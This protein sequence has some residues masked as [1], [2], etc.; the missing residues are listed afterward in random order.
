MTVKF[1]LE[2]VFSS[3]FQKRTCAYMRQL[4]ISILHLNSVKTCFFFFP[5]KWPVNK[6][7]TSNVISGVGIQKFQI[8]TKLGP[9]L[10]PFSRYF[11]PLRGQSRQSLAATDWLKF[12]LV[13]ESFWQASLVA[14][15]VPSSITSLAQHSGCH[16]LME[17]ACALPS[18]NQ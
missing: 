6:D 18:L 2:L 17:H 8:C 13:W 4:E 1:I 9:M 5:N 11:V 10:S 3:V 14:Q 12:P 7:F 16:S 15:L